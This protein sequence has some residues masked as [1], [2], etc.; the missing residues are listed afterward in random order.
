MCAAPFRSDNIED[1]ETFMKEAM[2]SSCEGLMV[3]GLDVDAEYVPNKRNWLKLK[4][5][6]LEG[7]GDTFDLVPIGAF[8]GTLTLVWSFVLSHHH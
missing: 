2:N 8:H 5:D 4:K 6:Y 1:I 3:K 7:V